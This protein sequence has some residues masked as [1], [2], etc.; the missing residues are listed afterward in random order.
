M[1]DGDE[2][3]NIEIPGDLLSHINKVHI[4][5]HVD[6]IRLNN[7]KGQLLRSPQTPEAKK[8]L[9]EINQILEKGYEIRF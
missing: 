1:P 2:V 6:R 3:A 7:E 4:L 5:T 9:Q 8:R